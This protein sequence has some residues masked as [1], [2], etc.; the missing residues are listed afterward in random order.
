MQV[1]ISKWDCL[2]SGTYE[3]IETNGKLAKAIASTGFGASPRIILIEHDKLGGL[4]RNDGGQ[5]MPVHT[6]WNIEKTKIAERQRQ[7]EK[8]GE[9]VKAVTTV[10]KYFFSI[11]ASLIVAYLVY[12]FGWN[13]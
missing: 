5:S 11:L 10:G 6:F 12:K 8:C 3:L 4:I 7:K 2:P 9:I 13:R 1:K